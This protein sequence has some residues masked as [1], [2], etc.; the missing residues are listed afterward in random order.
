M[1]F[2]SAKTYLKIV[3]SF[4]THYEI[5]IHKLPRLNARQ[6]KIPAPIQYND[7]PTKEMIRKAVEISNPLMKSLILFLSSTGMSKVDALSLQLSHF[8]KATSQY[9]TDKDLTTTISQLYQQ[10]TSE[11]IIPTWKMRRQKTGKYFI[12]FSSHE[13]T[14]AILEYLCIRNLIHT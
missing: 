4:Y 13:S 12:T 14:V 11:D 9:H 6:S 8:I 3:K 5:E 7:L 10:S 2:N 1:T